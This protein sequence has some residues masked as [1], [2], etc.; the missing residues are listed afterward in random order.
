MTVSKLMYNVIDLGIFLI[1]TVQAE[2]M[3]AEGHLKNIRN[4]IQTGP[5]PTWSLV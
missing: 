1:G 2:N 3:L 5:R 4:H